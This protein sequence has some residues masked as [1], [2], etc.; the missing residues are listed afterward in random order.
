MHS[1]SRSHPLG[2]STSASPSVA[3]FLVPFRPLVLSHTPR[4]LSLTILLSLSTLVVRAETLLT[5]GFGDSSLAWV[6]GD[7]KFDLFGH[8]DTPE[9][10][11]TPSRVQKPRHVGPAS[12]ASQVSAVC[13]GIPV[14]RQRACYLS[15]SEGGGKWAA[16]SLGWVPASRSDPLARNPA[17]LRC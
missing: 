13:P 8:M 3:H 9:D 5:E 14:R 1:E 11:N 17:S 15:C 10:T 16:S 6:W 12:T 2:S 7:C 4:P